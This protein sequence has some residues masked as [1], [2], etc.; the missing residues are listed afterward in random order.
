MIKQTD[1]V[2]YKVYYKENDVLK[3]IHCDTFASAAGAACGL[4]GVYR[5]IDVYASSIDGESSWSATL[6][7]YSSLDNQRRVANSHALKQVLKHQGVI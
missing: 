2:K 6:Y 5:S 3:T 1:V 4:N 7:V